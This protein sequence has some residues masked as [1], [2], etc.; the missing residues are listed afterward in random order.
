MSRV[1]QLG[2]LGFEVSDLAAWEQFAT[3]VLGVGIADRYEDGGFSLCWDDHHHRVF[4][5]PGERDDLALVGFECA[6][7]SDLLE[8]VASLRAAGVEVEEGSADD[9]ASRRVARLFRFREIGGNKAEVFV[10]PARAATKFASAL[11]PSGFVADGQGLGHCVLR[12]KDRVAAERW[13]IDVLG[14]KLSDHIICDIGGFHVDIA[15]LHTNP[16]HHSIALG[17]KLPKRIHHF[18]LQVGA[19]DDV[20]R[21]FDRCTDSRVQITQTLGRHPNDEML[22]F[23]ALTPSG[24]EFEYGWGARS[25]DDATWVPG[26][27]DKI[28]EWGHRR[29]PY[30]KPNR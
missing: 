7:E 11:V 19:L 5:R 28:S 30:P 14:F 26:L 18:M 6:T 24:F 25:V 2:Y 1:S 16:R 20:G 12:V 10:G 27:Y 13:Y 23:Y 3:H 15:F 8:T 9:A 17:E 4:V 22:S 21:A 29:L